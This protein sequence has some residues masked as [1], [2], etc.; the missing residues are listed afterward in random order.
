MRLIFDGNQYFCVI[1]ERLVSIFIVSKSFSSIAGFACDSFVVS[2]SLRIIWNIVY[3]YKH[4]KK[5]KADLK[6]RWIFLK[7]DRKNTILY[8]N[9][10]S[11]LLF[12]HESHWTGTKYEYM[13]GRREHCCF[14]YNNKWNMEDNILNHFI[15]L[16]L[17]FYI[18][19]RV[20]RTMIKRQKCWYL[21]KYV[22]SI[23]IL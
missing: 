1:K 4:Q 11:D 10:V 17:Q 7:L 2:S 6:K 22:I 13:K 21:I 9:I 14:F 5:W 20:Y 12:F 19:R 8:N 18:F 23:R 3:I 15:I 16:C